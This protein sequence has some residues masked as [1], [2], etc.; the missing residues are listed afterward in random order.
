MNSGILVFVFN[1]LIIVCLDVDLFIL[2]H[3]ELVEILG[4]VRSCLSSNFGHFGMLFF[5]I[6]FLL[7]FLIFASRIHTICLLVCLSVSDRSLRL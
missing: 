5:Q 1:S 3:L 6:M 7:L 4:I 2:L